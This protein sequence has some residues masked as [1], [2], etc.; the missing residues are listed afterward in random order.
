MKKIEIA[1]M[2]AK[3]VHKDDRYGD[4]VYFDYHLMN[5]YRRAIELVEGEKEKEIVG[6]VA[7]LHDIVEDHGYDVG[8]IEKLFGK[9]IADAVVAMSYDKENESREEYYERILKN[10][11]AKIVKIADASENRWNCEKDGDEKRFAYYD[12]IVKMMG[13]V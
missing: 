9:K 11:I 6:V 7:I 5:V 12:K 2:I 4:K 8:M 10:E 1:M 3:E 13:G